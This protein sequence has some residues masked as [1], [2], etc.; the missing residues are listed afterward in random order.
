MSKVLIPL[1]PGFEEIEAVTNIDVLRRASIEVVTTGLDSLRVQGGHGIIIT[2]DKLIDDVNISEFNGIVLPG[3]IP[4]ANN[5][6]E[7]SKVLEY[8]RKLNEKDGLLAA[9]CAAPIVL[10]AADL[11]EGKDATSYPG[12][13]KE[14]QSCNYLE[15]MVVRDDNIITGRGPGVALEF[16]LT[17]VEY[18]ESKKYADDLRKSMLI[19]N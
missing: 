19:Q 1:A 8:L 16:A 2:A 17:I 6:L 3:G 10:E 14:M 12:F 18:L 15:E 4:G 9:I 13:A 7:S 11:L 5:L